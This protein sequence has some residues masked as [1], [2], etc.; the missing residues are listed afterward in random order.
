MISNVD[1]QSNERGEAMYVKG[2]LRVA[3][4]QRRLDE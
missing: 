2:I 1:R 3:V 4:Y